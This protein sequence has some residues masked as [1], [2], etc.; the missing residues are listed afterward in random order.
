MSTA[1]WFRRLTWR[2]WVS[3]AFA[4]VNTVAVVLVLWAIATAGF[5]PLW[6]AGSVLV[7]VLNAVGAWGNTQTVLEALREHPDQ[8]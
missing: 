2:D 7:L 3:A 5:G 4:A 8:L 6:L 1:A